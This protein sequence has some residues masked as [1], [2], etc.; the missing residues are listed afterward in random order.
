MNVLLLT[1]YGEPKNKAAKKYVPANLALYRAMEGKVVRGKPLP[2]HE[3]I[4]SVIESALHSDNEGISS[5]F[6][7][8]AHTREIATA[9]ITHGQ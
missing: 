7:L 8:F 5:Q 3:S 9:I 4:N 6:T 2:F 1:T